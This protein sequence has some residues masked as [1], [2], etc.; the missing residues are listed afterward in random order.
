MK[1][2]LLFSGI[3]HFI[4]GATLYVSKG[5]VI[6]KSDVLSKNPKLIEFYKIP[7]NLSGRFKSLTNLSQRMFRSAVHHINKHDD[8][9]IVI[10]FGKIWTID[11]ITR[12]LLREP[13]PL[14]GSRPINLCK[15]PLGLFYGEYH[16]NS[17]REPI[18]LFYTSDGLN[19]SVFSS[20]DNVRHIHAV[21]YDPFTKTM[22]VTT[23]D[24]DDESAI[25]NNSTNSP[26]TF[27]PVI[28]GTQQ[29]RAIQL[30]FFDDSVVYG[31]DTP[32][33]SNS[34]YKID[35]ETLSCTNIAKVN[36][37]V[38]HSTQT[39][40]G[41]YFSTAVEPSDVN[42]TNLATIYASNNGIKWDAIISHEKDKW[43]KKIFQYGQLLFP[44]GK[45]ETE[46]LI[47]STFAVSSDHKTYR[48]NV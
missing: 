22:W 36:G 31:S 48:V 23:G 7:L 45:N 11:I 27:S 28:Q 3:A 42:N 34:I 40:N 9:L 6:Y 14:E 1:K 8:K 21:F 38:F 5:N 26:K 47:Y 13:V 18:R 39:C 20:F 10:G 30:L 4:D 12:K 25:W 29:A 16:G 24:E 46:Q 17:E 15:T 37:S 44:A 19:W 43:H 41:F 2:E 32:L 35:R 33:E